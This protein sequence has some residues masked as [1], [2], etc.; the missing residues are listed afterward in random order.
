MTI[1]KGQPWGGTVDR[2]ERVRF[3]DD[4]AAVAAALTDGSGDPVALAGGDL[5]RT[6]GGR[7]PVGL[8]QLLELPIDLLHVTLDGQ[9][10][11]TACAHVTMQRPS[12]RG[13]WWFGDVVMVMNAEFIGDWHIVA[14]GHPND[15][16]AE[17][18]AWTA[19]FGVRQRWEARRRL[20]GNAHIPH[21]QIEVRSIKQRVWEFATPMRVMIDG[22]RA[23]VARRVGVAVVADAAV[24]YA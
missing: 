7:D 19:D 9:P 24:I 23:G 22:E 5:H 3:F 10:I 14:R 15:G 20:P 17:V 21:P 12:L 1:E 18:C 11:R 13:G 8:A 16:R 2:P 4:D 6:V